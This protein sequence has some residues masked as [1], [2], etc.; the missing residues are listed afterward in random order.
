MLHSLLHF[1][2][3]FY[4]H[5]R[6]WSQYYLLFQHFRYFQLQTHLHLILQPLH[7]QQKSHGFR[8]DKQHIDGIITKIANDQAVTEHLT[9]SSQAI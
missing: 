9:A 6:Q 8:I 4:L 5:Y 7:Q 2:F 1:L 3:H